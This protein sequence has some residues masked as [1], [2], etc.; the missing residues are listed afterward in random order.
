MLDTG[1]QKFSLHSKANSN[2]IKSDH[3]CYFQEYLE[4]EGGPNESLE[5]L[6]SSDV[7]YSPNIRWIWIRPSLPVLHL[8][9]E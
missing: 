6:A 5:P 8:T 9:S 1:G 4:Q 3:V 7:N 2:S